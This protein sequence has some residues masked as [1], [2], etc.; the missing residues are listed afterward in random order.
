M[1]LLSACALSFKPLFRIVAK[2]LH[3]QSV[4]THTKSTF[5]PGK[6]YNNKT[7]TATQVQ[8]EM[9][10]VR[11]PSDET[12]DTS[13]EDSVMSKQ[14]IEVLITKTVEVELQ[15]KSGGVM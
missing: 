7:V 13:S 9:Q 6:S 8:F 3:L 1:Y 4:I 11:H 14:K 2:T 10:H 12:W 15:R 5:Q